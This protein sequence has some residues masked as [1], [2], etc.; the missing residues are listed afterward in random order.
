MSPGELM[1]PI[2]HL[3]LAA[4]YRSNTPHQ[5]IAS[6]DSLPAPSGTRSQILPAREPVGD[7]A[8]SIEQFEIQFGTTDLQ[9]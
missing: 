7:A 2:K 5:V 6:S 8:N 4:S 1:R 9:Q 3:V